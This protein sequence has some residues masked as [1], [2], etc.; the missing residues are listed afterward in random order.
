M[1]GARYSAGEESLPSRGMPSRAGRCDGTSSTMAV[2]SR[3]MASIQASMRATSA[4]RCCSSVCEGRAKT[5][6]WRDRGQAG[7][8]GPAHLMR[9]VERGEFRLDLSLDGEAVGLILFDGVEHGQHGVCAGGDRLAVWGA[10]IGNSESD[11]RS[12]QSHINV[13]R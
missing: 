2:C 6:G 9:A 13:G 7:R 5:A 11:R 8:A 3:C 12:G 4:A 1:H 10:R